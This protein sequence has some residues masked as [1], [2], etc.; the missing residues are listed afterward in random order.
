MPTKIDT[1]F[2]SLLEAT[3]A[4]VMLLS[5]HGRILAVN[6]PLQLLIKRPRDHLIFEKFENIIPDG[7]LLL[8]QKSKHGISTTALREIPVEEGENV[9]VLISANQPLMPEGHEEPLNPGNHEIRWVI[10]LTPV[11]EEDETA[12]LRHEMLENTRGGVS[13]T[14]MHELKN[15]LAAVASTLEVLQDEL[16]PGQQLRDLRM[17]LNEIRR[18]NL[19]LEGFALG[20][21]GIS[22]EWSQNITSSIRDAWLVL[23]RLAERKGIK[24]SAEIP[25][26]PTMEVEPA[27]IRAILYNLVTNSVNACKEGDS[28]NV[29][30]KYINSEKALEIWVTDTGAGMSAEV[31]A[32]C[33]TPY[34]TTRPNGTGIGLALCAAVVQEA[35]GVF[36]I[37]SVQ[38]EGTRI[39]I[40]VGAYKISRKLPKTQT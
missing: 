17:A 5:K 23:S 33:Q 36:E 38:G 39:F 8:Q 25:N 18:L 6:V 16:P 26:L 29:R 9:K 28:I 12:Q 4:A 40:R 2:L 15:P 7:A 37:H 35:G 20:H 19:T 31:L 3:S 24:T 30:V 22:S 21:K 27:G 14:V 13:P 34:F 32:K 1:G 10:T 11:F